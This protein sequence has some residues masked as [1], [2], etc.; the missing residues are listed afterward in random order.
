[1]NIPERFQLTQ[2]DELVFNRVA[3]ALGRWEIL[4]FDDLIEAYQDFDALLK[5]QLL[6]LF[7]EGSSQRTYDWVR[8]FWIEATRGLL[9]Y[10]DTRN[11]YEIDKDRLTLM[12]MLDLAFFKP[13]KLLNTEQPDCVTPRISVVVPVYQAM[14]YIFE[15]LRSLYEQTCQ[16]FEVILV[17]DHVGHNEMLP[18]IIALFGDKRTRIVPQKVKK[19]LGAVLNTGVREAKG[20]YIARMDADDI[21]TPDRFEK[22]L[23]FLELHPELSVCSGWCQC[24][25]EE[26]HVI[27]TPLTNEEIFAKTFFGPPYIHALLMWKREDFVNHNLWYDE[28][29]VVE[30]TV[31]YGEMMWKVKGGNLPQV[32]L[33]YRRYRTSKSRADI[34]VYY[35]EHSLLRDKLLARL[36]QTLTP[37]EKQKVKLPMTLEDARRVLEERGCKA[38][39]TGADYD[40][41]MERMQPRLHGRTIAVW[42]YGVQGRLL[43]NIL[44]LKGFDYVLVDTILEGKAWFCKQDRMM[45]VN[46][47]QNSADVYYIVVSMEDVPAGIPETLLA[48]GYK[49]GQDFCYFHNKEGLNAQGNINGSRAG[50]QN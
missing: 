45:R 24:F 26:H 13:E 31:F 33:L 16:D 1:M 37:Q 39:Y 29:V 48:W 10:W 30:D 4:A 50:N 9:E 14:P 46:E 11:L 2:E 49:Q 47:L 32:L 38:E 5:R 25:H 22:Q 17:D 40:R 41:F 42:G 27:Q 15:A 18:A 23:A 43:E 12:E 8:F 19:H 35:K 6:L 7:E 34:Q 36:E 20:D 3:Q 21:S 44:R 28:E